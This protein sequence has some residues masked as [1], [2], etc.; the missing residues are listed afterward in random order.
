MK[1]FK[2]QKKHSPEI[3]ITPL[4]DIIFILLIF[5]M[6]SSTFLKPAIEIK[7]PVA[8]HEDTSEREI[9]NLFVA[10]DLS[11]F[12]EDEPIAIENLQ[13]AIIPHT[14]INPEIAVMLFCDKDILFENAVTVIDILKSSG[15]KNLA[16]GHTG[17]TAQ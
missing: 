6:V 11:I 5:F 4:I 8:A 9:I 12:I 16:I 15:I 10:N 13:A 1:L 3:N 17:S 14:S 2:S 7:L